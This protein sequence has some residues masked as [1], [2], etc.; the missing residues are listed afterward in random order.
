MASESYIL[1]SLRITA[2]LQTWGTSWQVNEAQQFS[3]AEEYLEL[4]M[5]DYFDCNALSYNNPGI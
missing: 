1:A 4:T 5:I 3:L 2:E